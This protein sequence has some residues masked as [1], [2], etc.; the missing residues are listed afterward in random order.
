MKDI[1]CLFIHPTTHYY[2]DRSK[3]KDLITF[4]TMPLGTIAIADLLYRNGFSTKIIHSGIE[5]IYNRRF[6]IRNIF[7]K[8]DPQVVGIDLHWYVHSY[9]AIRISEITKKH[10]NA[11]VVMGGFTASFFS[12][13]ILSNFESVDS[14]ITGDA[15]IPMLKLMQSGL[16]NLEKVPNLVYRE[17]DKIRSSEKRYI[18][19][20]QDIEKL[21][22]TNFDLLE[23]YDK[24][25]RAINQSGDIGPYV[26]KTPIKKL[27]WTPIG[28]GCSVN[29]SYCGGGA[30]AHNILIGRQKPIYHPIEQVVETL[31]IFEDKNIDST[32]MDFDPYKDRSYYHKLFRLIRKENIDISVE[33]A[34]WSPSDRKFIEDFHKTFNPLYSTLVLS[35]E[36]GS[37]KVRRMNKG[38]FYD[39]ETL[40]KWMDLTEKEG[41]PLEIYFA[42][43]LSGETVDNFD[44]TMKL[45]KKIIDEYP[46]VSISCN[47]IQMEP[48]CNRFLNPEEYGVKLKFKK[49]MDF[50][51][52]FR[53]LSAGLTIESRLGYDTIW[54]NEEQILQ[55]S[56]KF[57]KFFSE[58][59]PQRLRKLEEGTASLKC[60]CKQDP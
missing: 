58:T 30:K 56:L 55:N 9:D 43:G 60:M 45:G 28:R 2:S 39:N 1:D 7:K 52:L 31:S 35:P 24:Y 42:S 47:P 57:D 50:Y 26:Y 44:E 25:H 16:N 46:V 36:S 27:A 37:E 21:K 11:F 34:L 49:F 59:Q 48:A 13:E 22:Y 8:Y 53:R 54:E 32:Y 20:E 15:E 51:H 4:V 23:N 6:R 10:T 29:C 12:E 41:V 17:N 5:Q 38:F 18:A 3:F 14:I 33:F 40:F 19:T